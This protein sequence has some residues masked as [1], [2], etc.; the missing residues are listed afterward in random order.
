MPSIR[1]LIADEHPIFCRG[2]R[3]VC[4]IEGG[5]EVL[6]EARD[7]RSLVEMAHR[8]QPDI[9]L[10]AARLPL[11]DGAQAIRAITEQDPNL[12]VIILFRKNACMF[13]RAIWAGARGYLLKD[14]NERALIRAIRAVHRGEVV[15]DPYV[16]AKMLDTLRD[17]HRSGGKTPQVERPVWTD[18][19]SDREMEILRL[20]A[21][22]L[23]NRAIAGQ[24][25]V[26]Q[27]TVSNYLISLYRKLDVN[28]R[29]QAAL[30]ALRQGWTNLDAGR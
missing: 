24:L 12:G 22:G 26:A 23:D 8:L 15:F 6:A 7:G 4:E 10:M 30:Y 3:Y 1:I 17:A 25:H 11:M 9:V 5:F 19:L 21:Q 13:E 16:T 2:L 18:S 28:N 29:T 20:V 14:V 27:K